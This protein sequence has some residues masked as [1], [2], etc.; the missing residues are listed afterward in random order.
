M[1][2]GSSSSSNI[3]PLFLVAGWGLG[4]GLCWGGRVGTWVAYFFFY[5]FSG[6]Y[7]SPNSPFLLPWGI[8]ADTYCWGFFATSWGF[9]ITYYS[10]TGDICVLG[11]TTI[12]SSEKSSFLVSGWGVTFFLNVNPSSYSSSNKVLFLVGFFFSTLAFGLNEKSSYSSSNNVFFLT[13]FGFFSIFGFGFIYS[14]SSSLKSKPLDLVGFFWDSFGRSITGRGL[15][16]TFG[17]AIGPTSDAFVFWGWTWG[18]GGYFW[19]WGATTG[20]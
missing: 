16:L 17:I 10:F 13:Y 12:Y 11:F 4:Y 19:G 7:S 14:S 3:S 2:I 9:L 1:I 18:F 8:F 20:S 6:Y 5:T 15:G